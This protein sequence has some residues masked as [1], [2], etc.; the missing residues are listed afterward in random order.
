[1]NIS[2]S[3]FA[4][5]RVVSRDG[6]GS[7]VPRQ[8]AHLH[9]LAAAGVSLGYFFYIVFDISRTVP[10]TNLRDS[11]AELWDVAWRS[12]PAASA[13]IDQTPLALLRR[14]CTEERRRVVV[15]TGVLRYG[16]TPWDNTQ[17]NDTT[18]FLYS[19]RLS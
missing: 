5:E 4:L 6:F 17:T 15:L 3:L 12:T 18:P 1:M 7:P 8:P 10:I 11:T 19:R 14:Q 13:S 16:Q 9:T 2:L